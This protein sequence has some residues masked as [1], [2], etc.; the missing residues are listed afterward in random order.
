MKTFGCWFHRAVTTHGCH[1]SQLSQEKLE[2]IKS[3]NWISCTLD[4]IWIFK[5]FRFKKKNKTDFKNVSN[6]TARNEAKP[7]HG[8]GMYKSLKWMQLCI[9]VSPENRTQ[10][11]NIIPLDQHF[12]THLF[13]LV[14]NKNKKLGSRKTGIPFKQRCKTPR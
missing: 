5:Q 9:F 7:L 12:L 10:Q 13:M 3:K 2:D 11:F 8:V 14:K 6:M 4:H 1:S